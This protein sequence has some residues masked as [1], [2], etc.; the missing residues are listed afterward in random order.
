MPRNQW[1]TLLPFAL[2]MAKLADWAAKDWMSEQREKWI[3]AII[4]G[5]IYFW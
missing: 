2:D 5:V 1:M 3:E 4:R